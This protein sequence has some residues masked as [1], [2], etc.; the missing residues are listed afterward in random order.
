[1]WF[2]IW[3][4][5]L[6]QIW[7]TFLY[8]YIVFLQNGELFEDTIGA[9]GSAAIENGTK[10]YISNLGGVI[11]EWLVSVLFP[12]FFPFMLLSSEVSFF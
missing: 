7:I 5:L 12:F 8:A 2:V 3:C 10:L 4:H 6:V 11:G 9:G 1:M